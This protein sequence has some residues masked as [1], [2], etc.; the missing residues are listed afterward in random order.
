MHWSQWRTSLRNW[1][2][3]QNVG[4]LLLGH[5]PST[6]PTSPPVLAALFMSST[7]SS[8]TAPTQKHN[9]PSSV[10]CTKLIFRRKYISSRQPGVPLLFLLLI[11]PFINFNRFPLTT[12][13]FEIK[14]ANTSVSTKGH[15]QLWA[16]QISIFLM[17]SGTRLCPVTL[18]TKWFQLYQ[19]IKMRQTKQEFIILSK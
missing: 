17:L 14:Y 15:V 5:I 18:T 3:L 1:G 6:N 11:M 2:M 10:S 8:L 9:Q 13:R 19:P 4:P 7:W 16:E 12:H